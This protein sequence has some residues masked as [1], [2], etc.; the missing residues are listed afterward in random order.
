MQEDKDHEGNDGETFDD[1]VEDGRET[2]TVAEQHKEDGHR[3]EE[4][5][6][7]WPDTLQLWRRENS[8]SVHVT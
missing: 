2:G 3:L 4:W 8:F 1:A 5:H 6:E 7:L